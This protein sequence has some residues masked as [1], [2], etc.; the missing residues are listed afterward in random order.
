M[1]PLLLAAGGDDSRVLL[2]MAVSRLRVAGPST[3]HAKA[4]V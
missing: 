4:A 1:M 3:I 2:A